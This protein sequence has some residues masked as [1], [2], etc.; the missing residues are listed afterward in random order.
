MKK[1]ILF[2]FYFFLV[3]NCFS[4]NLSSASLI[5]Y[6]KNLFGYYDIQLEVCIGYGRTGS[7][8]G[9]DNNT[10]SIS[11]AWYSQDNFF[12]I[13][14]FSPENITSSRGF[15]DCTMQGRD[16][17]PQGAPYNSQ[18]TIVYVDPGYYGEE[19]CLSHPYACITNTQLCG[20]IGQQCIYYNFTTYSIPDSIRIFGIEGDGFPLSGCYLDRDMTI[21]FELDTIQDTIVLDTVSFDISWGIIHPNPVSYPYFLTINFFSDHYGKTLLTV[22][23]TNGKNVFG[24]LK[25]TNPG[26][27]SIFLRDDL[28]EFSPGVYFVTLQG[29]KLK[30]TKK[31]LIL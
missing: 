9:A 26:E 3:F 20:N 18:A 30:I 5:R 31:I 7:A 6:H 22:Y 24:K 25:K 27:N 1:T 12:Q 17:G 2:V 13:I 28:Y 21:A 16:I 19:P 10:R 14:N 23:D 8:A 29:T 4:C 11:F 15:S